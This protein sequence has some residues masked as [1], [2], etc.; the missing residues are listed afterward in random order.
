M[1]LQEPQ[2][3]PD[4]PDFKGCR[5]SRAPKAFQARLG[6]LAL[7]ESPGRRELELQALQAPQVLQA[8]RGPPGRRGCRALGEL[9]V[10]PALPGP[11]ELLA[12]PDL[13]VFRDQWAPQA[14]QEPQVLPAPLGF[15][16]CRASRGPKAFQALRGPPGRRELEELQVPQALQALRAPLG[17]LDLLPTM[18]SLL[19]QTIWRLSPAEL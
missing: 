19:L 18:Y 12:R 16:V 1:D 9:L 13:P 8:L 5:A 17:R 10:P 4:P 11:P 7:R 6:P 15:K 3:L 2:A 14:L